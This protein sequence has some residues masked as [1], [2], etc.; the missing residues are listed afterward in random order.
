MQWL[1][2]PAVSPSRCLPAPCAQPSSAHLWGLARPHSPPNRSSQ[3]PHP[4][5]APTPAPS[6]R[7]Q[8]SICLLQEVCPHHPRTRHL[9]RARVRSSHTQGRDKGRQRESS[10]STAL[11]RLSSLGGG[12][13]WRC[14]LLAG[15]QSTR[16]RSH[17]GQPAWSQAFT[18]CLHSLSYFPCQL[19]GL[20]SQINHVNSNPHLGSAL[21]AHLL[22]S[23]SLPVSWGQERRQPQDS[24]K[25][26][27][28]DPRHHPAFS[29]RGTV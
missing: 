6:Y 22:A 9:F 8:L 20:T 12:M 4:S 19:P 10:Q 18:S 27:G 2:P 7:T 11:N 15:S 1:C 25:D 16:L 3:L 29:Q 13:A 26:S 5:P 14:M 23:A 17:L 24:H 28:G 21:R